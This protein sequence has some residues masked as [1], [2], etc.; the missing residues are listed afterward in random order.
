MPCR[1][2][3]YRPADRAAVRR[4]CADTGC[5]GNPIDPVFCDRD[6]FADYLTRYYTD[7]EPESATVAEDEVTGEVVGYLLGCRRHRRNAWIGALLLLGLI[8]PKGLWRIGTFRYNRASLRFV[9]W[10][11]TRAGRET[12]PAPKGMAHFHINLLPPY[13]NGQATRQLIF[14][15]VKALAARGEVAGVFGQMQVR[16]DTRTARAFERYGFQILER[17]RISKLDHLTAEPLY[18]ATIFM[19]FRRHNPQEGRA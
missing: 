8:I 13:R 3:P 10:I 6:V 16:D 12:P 17:R 11:L 14:P 2:R 5:M 19:D 15:Y 18:L 7:W 9:G 4:I 1:I